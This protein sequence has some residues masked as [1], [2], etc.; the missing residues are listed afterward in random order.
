MNQIR[1]HFDVL[2]A[3]AAAAETI[4]TVPNVILP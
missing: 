3:A 1:N 4:P 2:V